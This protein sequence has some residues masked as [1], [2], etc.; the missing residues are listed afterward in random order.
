[1]YTY[2]IFICKWSYKYHPIYTELNNGP[3]YIYTELNN[4][5]HYVSGINLLA[6][7]RCGCNCICLMLQLILSFNVWN[8]YCEISLRWTSEELVDNKSTVG[9]IMAWCHQVTSYYL[10]QFWSSSLMSYGVTR[11]PFYQHELPFI[12]AWR[13]D[14]IVYKHYNDII[15]TTIVSQ[16][17]SLTV[18]YSTVYSDA[19]QRKHQ[20]SASLAFVWGVSRWIPR[21]K[22]QL[23]GKCFYWMTSSWV[24]D[25]IIYSFMNGEVWVWIS[26]IVPYLTRHVIT[27]PGMLWLKFTHAS[28]RRPLGPM[29]EAENQMLKVDPGKCTSKY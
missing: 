16:I 29:S 9:Q 19:D 23:R 20:S 12:T 11:G 10:T 1:M 2:Q 24:W 17:T 3:H 7:G 5:P 8:N 15:M 18:V 22:G 28:K 21:T 25:E 13:S 4:G 26:N 6:C 14:Y 27:Y